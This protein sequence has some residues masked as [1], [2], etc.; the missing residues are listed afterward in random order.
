LTEAGQSLACAESLTAGLLCAR[1]ADVAGASAVLRGGLVTYATDLKASILGV[2]PDLLARRGAV[3]P[4]VAATM[5]GSVRVLLGATWGV[6]TTGVAGPT[7]QDGHPVGEV[8]V[9][10]AGP[11]GEG[12]VVGLGVR[13][14]RLAGSRAQIREQAVA[15]ALRLLLERLDEG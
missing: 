2:D 12:G 4:E 5:A 10:V 1:V 3:D 15:A 14:L 13:A 6:A 9:A 8:Y 11:R 7:E